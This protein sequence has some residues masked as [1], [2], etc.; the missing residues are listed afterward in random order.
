M[1]DPS[2]TFNESKTTE[3]SSNMVN[4]NELEMMS[5]EIDQDRINTFQ[6]DVNIEQGWTLKGRL[7]TV[8]DKD[9]RTQYQIN[10]SRTRLSYSTMPLL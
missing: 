8:Q 1:M 6:T 7:T 2:S 3:M 4:Y 10:S 5:E 9:D